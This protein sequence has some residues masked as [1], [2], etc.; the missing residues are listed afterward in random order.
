MQWGD[1]VNTS[2]L[3]KVPRPA[4]DLRDQLRRDQIIAAARSC[5]VRHGFHGATMAEIAAA[6]GMSVGQIY[7]YF[8]SKEAIVHAIVEGIVS[9]RLKLMA[10]ADWE[11]SGDM[12]RRLMDDVSSEERENHVLMLEVTAEATR[13][14]AVAD[15]AKQADQR[16]HDQAIESCIKVC[17]TLSLPEAAAR[18]ELIA[19]LWEGTLFRRVTGQRAPPD[20]LI[21]R[22][23]DVIDQVMP[24]RSRQAQDA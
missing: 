19:A 20:I 7:R 24:G 4:K 13:N 18:V 12:V 22:Y 1:R 10:N 11:D 9:R 23:R 21:K 17:P 2:Q 5:V 16:L 3:P 8:C 6:A 14:S 15:I